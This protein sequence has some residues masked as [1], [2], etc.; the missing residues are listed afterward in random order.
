MFVADNIVDLSSFFSMTV[1][2]AMDLIYATC[3]AT[4]LATTA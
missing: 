1:A 3:M 2:M 4:H